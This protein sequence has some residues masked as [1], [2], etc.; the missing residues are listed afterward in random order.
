MNIKGMVY[1][2]TIAKAGSL[3]EAARLLHI[4]QPTLSVFLSN[5]ETGL[6]TDLF[7]RNKK[8][9]VLT[10]AGKIYCDAA[11]RI[12]S[13]K[14][15][16]Y[17]AVHRL[18]HNLTE[19]IVVGATPLRGAVMVAQIFPQFSKRY[20]DV[21]LEIKESYMKDL[22]THVKEGQASFALASCYD[23]EEPA[24]DHIMI[25]KEE[26]LM[27]VP[28]FHPLAS[29]MVS[30]GGAFP[31][32]DPVQFADSPFI[33]LSEGTTVRAIS[34]YI[35]TKVGFRPTVVFETNNNLVLSN[36]IR[37]GAGVG[38]LPR[39]A[40]VK[41]A[42]DIAYFSLEP[43]YYLGLGIIVDKNRVLTEA[44]RYLAYLVI[45]K[46]KDNPMYTPAMNAYARQIFREFERRD[47][48][49]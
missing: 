2:A 37:Q 36:M 44:E 12:I 29:Q 28:S 35:C 21:K 15:Q 3:S 40:V 6:G 14:D 13:V 10:P 48:I 17:Q 33:L 9:L 31:A 19:T 38:F 27:G 39:S 30:T 47:T 25:S 18:S 8:K 22:R 7:L 4:S 24:F 49:L 34:D 16:T 23:S 43:R 26:L 1:F 32:I 5:L 41:D 42:T 45:R 11:E 20:P 46:D